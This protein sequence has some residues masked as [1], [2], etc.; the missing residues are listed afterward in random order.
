MEDSRAQKGGQSTSALLPPTNTSIASM[1]DLV[2]LSSSF[3]EARGANEG[4]SDSPTLTGDKSV[5]G[6]REVKEE[7]PTPIGAAEKDNDESSCEADEMVDAFRD[8]GPAED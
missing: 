3:S 2:A 4:G 1:S 8:G 6:P 5:T 7:T